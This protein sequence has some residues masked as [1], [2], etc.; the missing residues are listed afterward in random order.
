VA[1]R[2]VALDYLEASKENKYSHI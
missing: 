1:E 2:S